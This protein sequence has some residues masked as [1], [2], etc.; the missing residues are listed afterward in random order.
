MEDKVN[1]NSPLKVG[2]GINQKSLSRRFLGNLN[3]NTRDEN[4]ERNKLRC[5]EAKEL[6]AY[7]KGQTHFYYGKD[8]DRNPIKHEVRQ[9][10]YYK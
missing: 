8:F 3:P 9:E 7:L 4:K 2:D 1:S 10:Y 6:K 5:F